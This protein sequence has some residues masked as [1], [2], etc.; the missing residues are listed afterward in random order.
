MR[1]RFWRGGLLGCC[2]VELTGVAK[3]V[4]WNE[5]AEEGWW[6]IVK[7]SCGSTILFGGLVGGLVVVGGESTAE[8]GSRW[9]DVG[10]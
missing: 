4:V 8:A 3:V 5:G 7:A 1:A 6:V 2:C 10:G 9:L